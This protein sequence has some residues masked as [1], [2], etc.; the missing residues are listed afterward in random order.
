MI[1]VFL[2]KK[3]LLWQWPPPQWLFF[4]FICRGFIHDLEAELEI[5]AVQQR[6]GT[7]NATVSPRIEKAF[8]C[9]SC[10]P[11][12]SNGIPKK[13]HRIIFL[14]QQFLLKP[15]NYLIDNTF[16]ADFHRMTPDKAL[17]FIL[18]FRSGCHRVADV[19]DVSL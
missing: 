6:A 4:S 11:I 2:Y 15:F 5:H 12:I 8:A 1:P 17:Q 16:S 10:T 7:D 14:K 9:W 13:Q 18:F 19:Q 3:P